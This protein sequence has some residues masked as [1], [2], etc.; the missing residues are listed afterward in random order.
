MQIYKIGRK[1]VVNNEEW[2]SGGQYLR[3]IELYLSNLHCLVRGQHAPREGARQFD[4]Q[5]AQR[6]RATGR[7][8]G[9]ETKYLRYLVAKYLVSSQVQDLHALRPRASAD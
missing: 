2:W 4:P 9:G 8:R 3:Y 6:A 7:G 1:W 5:T